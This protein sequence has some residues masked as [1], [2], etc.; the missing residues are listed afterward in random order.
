MTQSRILQSAEIFEYAT[1]LPVPRP[2]A[3]AFKWAGYIGNPYK[4][5]QECLSKLKKIYDI[6]KES[7]KQNVYEKSA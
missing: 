6:E 2:P 3:F 5:S 1:N 7:K 4:M